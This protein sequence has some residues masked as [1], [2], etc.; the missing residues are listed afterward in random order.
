[1]YLHRFED[2]VPNKD[3][4]RSDYTYELRGRFTLIHGEGRARR[5][6][7]KEEIIRSAAG[8]RDRENK[9]FKWTMG[10]DA[11]PRQTLDRPTKLSLGGV[12]VTVGKRREVKAFCDLFLGVQ[13]VAVMILN[14][15]TWSISFLQPS[16]FGHHVT[17]SRGYPPGEGDI[18]T[19]CSPTGPFYLRESRNIK[20]NTEKETRDSGDE[21]KKP[22]ERRHGLRETTRKNTHQSTVRH[23]A[24]ERGYQ[25]EKGCQSW[26]NQKI[27]AHDI[28]HAA[29]TI[30]GN[31]EMREMN[32]RDYW[33]FLSGRGDLEA[34]EMVPCQELV[35]KEPTLEARL[36][37]TPNYEMLG[38]TLR[39]PIRRPV[40]SD[41]TTTPPDRS[42]RQD[43]S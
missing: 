1:M 25:N 5:A 29:G 21:K 4:G 20:S 15:F 32:P 13:Q 40:T 10:Q 43:I 34:R 24:G 12:T 38:P 37:K 2:M 18:S 23:A 42:S 39:I 22:L 26:N 31:E 7:L 28:V 41:Q 30:N 16:V 3:S 6:V 33:E 11:H 27:Q 36:A 14:L 35:G 19:P 17:S 8:K 9:S